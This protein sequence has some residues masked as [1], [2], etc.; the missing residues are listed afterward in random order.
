[1]SSAG[2]QALETLMHLQCF[3]CCILVSPVRSTFQPCNMVVMGLSSPVQCCSGFELTRSCRPRVSKRVA[4][5]TDLDCKSYHSWFPVIWA[6][7]VQLASSE[8]AYHGAQATWAL[9]VTFCIS[10]KTPNRILCSAAVEHG[11]TGIWP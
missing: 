3:C 10:S 1:M 11:P 4:H 5:W 7:A 6:E 8:L 9:F 2:S